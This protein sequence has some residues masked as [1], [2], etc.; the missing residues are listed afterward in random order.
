MAGPDASVGKPP[1]DVTRSTVG[2]AGALNIGPSQVV[3]PAP[4]LTV[5][6]QHTLSGRGTGGLPS[7]GVQPV[8]PP[9]SVGGAGGSGAS[10]RLI[11][12]GIHPVA[13]T[14]PVATPGGNRRGTFAANPSGKAGAAGTP[15]ST[16]ASGTRASGNGVSGSNSGTRG[17]DS[18]L[19]GGLHVG[20][21]D[22]AS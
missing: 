19:P 13:P 3:A 7:G 4:Q 16:Q 12:L 21:A 11:A 5:A 18:S 20:A 15:G 9:P 14:G 1:P 22:S 10:G 2:R 6:Q 17:R 8:A